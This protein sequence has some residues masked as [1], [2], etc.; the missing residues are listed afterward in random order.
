MVTLKTI[1]ASTVPII[2][3][4]VA[5]RYRRLL[6][7]DVTGPP[8]RQ[9]RAAAACALS[10]SLGAM[11]LLWALMGAE[12]WGQNLAFDL[13]PLLFTGAYIFQLF[14]F[15]HLA[16]QWKTSVFFKMAILPPLVGCLLMILVWWHDRHPRQTGANEKL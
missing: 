4:A 9:V 14:L 10:T 2:A 11:A 3:L 16:E 12:Y 1:L 15:R 7:V 13:L 5:F 6:L 8:T